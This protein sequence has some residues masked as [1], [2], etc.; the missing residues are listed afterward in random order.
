[1]PAMASAILVQY[2]ACLRPGVPNGLPIIGRAPGWDKVYL[3]LVVSHNARSSLLAR[4]SV[5]LARSTGDELL[6]F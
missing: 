4:T 2:T 3:P 1:M 6:G 5:I